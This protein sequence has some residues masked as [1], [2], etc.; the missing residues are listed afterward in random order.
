MVVEQPHFVYVCWIEDCEDG[1]FS[2][3]F[4]L[5]V[6]GVDEIERKKKE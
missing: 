4:Y 6:C 3:S 5:H 1:F 2:L